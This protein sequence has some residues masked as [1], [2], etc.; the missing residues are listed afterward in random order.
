MV[1]DLDIQMAWMLASAVGLIVL[2]F[3]LGALR[4][5]TQGTFDIR[6]LPEFLRTNVLPFVGGLV[7]LAGFSMVLPAVK[8]VYIAAVVATD[9]KFLA[10]IRDKVQDIFGPIEQ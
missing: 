1:L 10:E 3:L 5:Y 6:V 2:D 7:L 9:A 4:A 8:V